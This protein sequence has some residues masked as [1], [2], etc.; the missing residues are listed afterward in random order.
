MGSQLTSVGPQNKKNPE[1]RA[2]D[3]T[4]CGRQFIARRQ[5]ATRSY[6]DGYLRW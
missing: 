6:G 1:T 5:L 4:S 3:D 2:P